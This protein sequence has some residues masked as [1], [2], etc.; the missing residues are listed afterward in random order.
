MWEGALAAAKRIED[1]IGLDNLGPWSDF[2]WGMINGKQSALRWILG[3]VGHAR[4]VVPPMWSLT[5]AALYSWRR[6]QSRTGPN[7]L[8]GH[9]ETLFINDLC[10]LATHFNH[11]N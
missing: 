9:H 8:A 10:L 4:H 2:E 7:D 1:E 3:D 11:Q 5:E 6:S